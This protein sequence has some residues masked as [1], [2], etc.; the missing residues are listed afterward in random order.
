VL[1][2][3]IFIS[4]LVKHM[5]NGTEHVNVYA[6]LRDNETY[7]SIIYILITLLLLLLLLFVNSHICFELII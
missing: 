3:H 7:T 1:D 6:K 2:T 4:N 5:Y